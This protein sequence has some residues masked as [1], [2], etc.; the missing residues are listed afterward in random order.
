MDEPVLSA[1][2]MKEKINEALHALFCREDVSSWDLL[3][4]FGEI[5]GNVDE[6]IIN[7]QA[8]LDDLSEEYD[9]S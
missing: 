7:L 5:A 2:Q 6:H 4:I 3:Q 1:Q 9:R 8:E